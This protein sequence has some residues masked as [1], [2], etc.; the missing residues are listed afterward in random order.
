MVYG[1]KWFPFPGYQLPNL[2]AAS[3]SR[4][5]RIARLTSCRYVTYSMRD[6]IGIR[7]A[8]MKIRQERVNR[9]REMTDN[10]L[11]LDSHES[12]AAEALSAFDMLGLLFKRR[13]LIATIVAVVAIPALALLMLMPNRYTS[14][15]TVLPTVATDKFA[16]LKNLAGFGTYS[17]NAENSSE[18]FPTILR[19]RRVI[20]SVTS[21]YYEI[22]GE[23]QA[24]RLADYL[25]EDNPDKLRAKVAGL[26]SVA[27]DKR[28]GVVTVAVET[29]IPEL[30]RKM[31]ET[32]LA[33]LEHYNLHDR[34][35]RAKGNEKYLER[36]VK[37]REKEVAT[38]EAAL[39]DYRLKNRNWA[40]TSNPEII[41]EHGKLEREA[42]IKTSGFV[43]LSRE[44]EIAR[45]ETQKDLPIVNLLD[46]PSTPTTKS[47]PYRLSMLLAI[48]ATALLLGIVV[49]LVLEGIERKARSPE[50]ESFDRLVNNVRESFPRTSR[51][52]FSRKEE[53]TSV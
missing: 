31:L 27:T 7:S 6:Q 22:D 19:S 9:S 48:S 12:P 50:N 4:H 39:R 16:E 30:S 32:Y 17:A 26:T 3:E 21:T 23:S 37:L 18:L 43:Y 28:T 41:T 51:L 10:R 34:T 24:I 25:S 1:R 13:K 14:S 53:S 42:E 33:A 44:Y 15:A 45:I 47:G 52:I 2:G 8:Y 5:H 38:A 20:D 35:S 11:N 29:E 40:N 49:A 46:A 36:E